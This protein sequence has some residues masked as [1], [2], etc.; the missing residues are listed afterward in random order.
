MAETPEA[1]P[2]EVEKEPTLEMEGVK[3]PLPEESFVV[4]HM[5]RDVGVY[6]PFG[7]GEEL[8]IKLSKGG[9]QLHASW[10]VNGSVW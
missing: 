1:P 3:L 8:L 6:R 2:P 5:E 10:F 7:E 4:V 9:D